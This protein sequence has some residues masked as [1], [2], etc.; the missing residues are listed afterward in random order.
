MQRGARKLDRATVNSGL[1]D[2]IDAAVRSGAF[3]LRSLGFATGFPNPANPF[4]ATSWRVSVFTIEFAAMAK[5]RAHVRLHRG[6]R[7]ARR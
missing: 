7:T 6:A 1:R 2:C 4:F 5:S 3:S